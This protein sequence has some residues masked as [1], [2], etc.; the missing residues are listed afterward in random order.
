MT[1]EAIQGPTASADPMTESEPIGQ[2]VAAIADDGPTLD[3]TVDAS[4]ETEPAPAPTV[5]RRRKARSQT[6]PA[7]APAD[8]VDVVTLQTQLDTLAAQ[9][10]E[11]QTLLTT[12]QDQRVAAEQ[13]VQQAKED[14]RLKWLSENGIKN[15]DYVALAPSVDSGADVL[16][17]DGRRQL[18]RW[19][20]EHPELFSGAPQPPD[21]AQDN[22]AMDYGPKQW[23]SWFTKR[24]NGLVKD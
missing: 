5:K 14:A 24:I 19:R 6:E 21:V 1:N 8:A 13:A 4:T 2:T 10:S 11:T 7:P 22:P 15:Q 20:S 16:T 17:E 12:E 23:G 9:L 18:A 3:P